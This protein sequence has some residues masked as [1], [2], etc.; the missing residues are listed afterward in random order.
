MV[1]GDLL[2]R[3]PAELFQER[4]G[5]DEGGHR[6]AHDT[7]G[8]DGRYVRALHL[9]LELVLRF[10]IDAVQGLGQRGQRL[11]VDPDADLFAVGDAPLQAAGVIRGPVEAPRRPVVVNLV[12]ELRPHPSCGLD[13]VPD[14][15]RLDRLDR[16]DCGRQ[17]GVQAQVPVPVAPQTGGNTVRQDLERA[18]H[19]VAGLQGAIDLLDHL[20]LDS[21]VRAAQRRPFRRHDPIPRHLG[22][23][24]ERGR[25]QRHRVA[26]HLHIELPQELLAH[27]PD[28]HARRRLARRGPLEDVA[29]VLRVVLQG[30]G[31]VGMPGSRAREPLA[32]GLLDV[33]RLDGHRRLP[34]RPVAVGDLER[35]RAGEGAP[36]PHTGKDRH[37]VLLDLHPPAAPVAVLPAL[38]LDVDV[39]GQEPEPGRHPVQDGDQRRPVRLPRRQKTQHADSASVPLVATSRQIERSGDYP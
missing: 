19:G 15:D 5:Q 38:E 32:L 25:S 13:A 37:P 36:V 30:P 1:P 23:G 27:S 8:G 7:R 14:G 21:G 31:Q 20:L 9:R 12:V 4:L 29:C 2:E 18:A 22:Q 28:G 3:V 39:G 11:D 24:R 35:N 17:P 34:V 33:D 26:C 16:A 10:E 6:L